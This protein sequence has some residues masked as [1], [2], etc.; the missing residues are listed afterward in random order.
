MVTVFYCQIEY[1]KQSKPSLM[2]TFY[3]VC[4][5]HCITQNVNQTPPTHHFFSS[6]KFKL[7]VQYFYLWNTGLVTG[8]ETPP[9]TLPPHPTVGKNSVKLKGYYNYMILLLCNRIF[10]MHWALLVLYVCLSAKSEHQREFT[11]YTHPPK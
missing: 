6:Q 10:N 11:P 1:L 3:M 7:S 8:L 4:P 2:Y 9:P 5:R